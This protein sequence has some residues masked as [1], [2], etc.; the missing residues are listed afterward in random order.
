MFKKVIQKTN[1]RRSDY[2]RALLSDTMPG[3]IPIIVSNDGLYKNLN[4]TGDVNPWV[5]EFA[6]AIFKT[7]KSYTVPYRYDILRPGGGSRRLS[8]IHPAAQLRVVEFYREAGHL[9]CYYARRSRATL[10]APYKTASLSFVRGPAT[11]KNT[12]KNSGVDTVELEKAV[13]NP[14]SFFAYRRYTRAHQFFSSKDYLRLEKKYQSAITTDVSRCFSSIYTHTLYWAIVSILAGKEHGRSYTFSNEFDKIMQFMNFG[15]TNGICVGAEV[16]R[17][18]AEI[19]LGEIDR[20]VIADL[21]GSLRSITYGH[22]YEFY[23]YVD[24]YYIFADDKETA[25][26]V[27]TAISTSLATFNLHLRVCLESVFQRAILRRS[28]MLDAA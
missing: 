6:E 11:E 16:S 2:L 20:R 7:K 19:I 13:A 23:R 27:M 14:A 1:V 9:I 3:D 10:R 15:E 21:E 4:K 12:L 5:L 18:F 28:S 8:L 24:D 17:V 25:L 26:Q 22:Q